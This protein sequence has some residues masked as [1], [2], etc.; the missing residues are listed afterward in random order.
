MTS[1]LTVPT[2][3]HAVALPDS[4][5]L[6]TQRVGATTTI[7]VAGDIDAAT[8]PRLRE[9]L[10]C[11]A[12]STIDRL[13]IDLYD[14]TFIGAAGLA[15]LEHGYLMATARGITCTVCG[16]AAGQLLRLARVFQLRFTETMEIAGQARSA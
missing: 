12:S 4:L 3:P 16:D 7:E 13:V 14:V 11:R 6:T 15:A 5:R 9:L 2:S 1:Q 10:A 8:A